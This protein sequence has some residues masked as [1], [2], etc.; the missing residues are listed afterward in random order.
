M[1]GLGDV[2]RKLEW[3]T[4]KERSMRSQPKANVWH[5]MSW[6]LVWLVSMGLVFSIVAGV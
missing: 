3:T 2:P 1:T 5:T 6:A 4:D